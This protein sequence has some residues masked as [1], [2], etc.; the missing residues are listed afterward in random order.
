MPTKRLSLQ[1][2][3]ATLEQLESRSARTGEPVS[4]LAR[5][6]IEEGVRMEARPGINFRDGPAGRRPALEQ[7]PDVWEVARVVRAVQARGGR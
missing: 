2:D 3:S 4:D 7:G 5:R 6:H 1:I